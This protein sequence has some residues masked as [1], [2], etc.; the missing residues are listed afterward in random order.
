MN[1]TSVEEKMGYQKEAIL[2]FIPFEKAVVDPLHQTLRITDKLIKNLLIH[3]EVLDGD[4]SS[5]LTNCP[6]LKCLWDFIEIDCNITKP[7]EIKEKNN[8]YSKLRSLYKGEREEILKKMFQDQNL[9]DL[10][11]FQFHNDETLLL[12]NF[13]LKE[14]YELNMFINM[15][16]SEHFDEDSLR[17]RLIHWHSFYKKIEKRTTPYVH[18]FVEHVPYFISKLK[19]LSNFSLQGLEKKN[20]IL[21]NNFFRKTNR[22]KNEFTTTLLESINREELIY[23]DVKLSEI[24]E[25]I[26]SL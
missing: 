8:E 5:D 24:D 26:N 18:I 21:K 23:L 11:P 14:F 25:K 15:D 20:D 1:A 19:N 13:V 3:L 10:F 4:S 6:L 2:N 16:H 9:L 12:L 22:H 7:F 17:K